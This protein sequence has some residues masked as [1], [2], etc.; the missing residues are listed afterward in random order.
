MMKRLL[1]LLCA[2]TIAGCTTL[3]DAT[4]A[5]GTGV[6]RTFERPF[7]SVWD[8]ALLA[9]SESKLDLVASQRDRGE[10]LAQRGM[11]AFSYGE[12]VAIFVTEI[13]TDSTTVEVVSKRALATNVIAK[14]WTSELL[15]TI[16]QSLN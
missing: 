8:A 2:F 16:E 1:I 3:H 14:N 6:S 13:A 9:V 15:N 11:S 10:I 12:N 5:R 4:S 7:D